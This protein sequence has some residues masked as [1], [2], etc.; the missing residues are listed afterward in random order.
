MFNVSISKTTVHHSPSISRMAHEEYPR[1]RAHV[2]NR[3]HLKL[4][5]TGSHISLYEGDT[6]NSLCMCAFSTVK[7]SLPI[8]RPCLIDYLS[9]PQCFFPTVNSLYCSR[10]ASQ[11]TARQ[12]GRD[13]GGSCRHHLL[14]SD[15]SVSPLDRGMQ[16]QS[17]LRA[18]VQSSWGDRTLPYQSACP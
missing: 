12:A 6:A 5:C 2:G 3:C 17:S 7:G 13:A 18:E 11:S 8:S 4:G 9:V 10:S 16:E 14:N 1:K 15:H